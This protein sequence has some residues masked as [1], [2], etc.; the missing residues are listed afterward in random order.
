MN[1]GQP[2][3]FFSSLEWTLQH[4]LS[5]GRL[6]EDLLWS[7]QEACRVQDSSILEGNSSFKIQCKSVGSSQTHMPSYMVHCQYVLCSWCKPKE[8]V[9]PVV[10]WE[11]TWGFIPVTCLIHLQ[12]SLPEMMHICFCHAGKDV[13]AEVSYGGKKSAREK[14]INIRRES[15]PIKRIW[16]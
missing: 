12:F 9:V 14:K 6:W 16:E 15:S 5:E 4:T 2:R 7:L 1:P 10:V 3:I 8:G 13:N 11:W